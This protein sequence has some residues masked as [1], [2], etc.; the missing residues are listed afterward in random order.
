MTGSIS[1]KT[2]DDI[3]SEARNV[4]GESG[5]TNVN[6]SWAAPSRPKGDIIGYV[7]RVGGVEVRGCG[8]WGDSV[9]TSYDVTG[10]SPST[11]YQFMVAACTS[12]G[13]Y[14]IY[15]VGT[16][17]AVESVIVSEVSSFQRLKEWYLG[18]ENVSCLERCPQF[19]GYPYRPYIVCI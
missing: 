14:N 12:A 2:F 16:D 6:L 10:L 3:P 11:T 1:V 17:G 8:G 5:M 4:T 15:S 13:M 7:V 18:W 9:G 19:K